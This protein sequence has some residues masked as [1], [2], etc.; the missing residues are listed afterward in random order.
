MPE[1]LPEP[2]A[3]APPAPHQVDAFNA[4]KLVAKIVTGLGLAIAIA[5]AVLPAMTSV[6][7][8]HAPSVI[9]AGSIITAAGSVQ[10]ALAHMAFQAGTDN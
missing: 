2:H 6:L 5:G 10:H 7:G 4:E 1:P 8:A 9:V 3:A